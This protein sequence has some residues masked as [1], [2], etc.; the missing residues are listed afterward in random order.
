MV[1]IQLFLV[2]V[3][4]H[5]RIDGSQVDR[6]VG[7]RFEV[8]KPTIFIALRI[9]ESLEA[10]EAPV[11]FSSRSNAG[12]SDK[13]GLP[14][15]RTCK[16]KL[17]TCTKNYILKLIIISSLQIKCAKM[18]QVNEPIIGVPQ[19]TVIRKERRVIWIELN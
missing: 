17:K 1:L 6:N 14:G 4:H 19:K 11:Y 2:S 13:G 15:K 5:V 7:D 3:G 10:V 12:F 16:M 18:Q 9:R 8:H